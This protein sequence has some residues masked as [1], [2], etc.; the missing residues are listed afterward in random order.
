MQTFLPQGDMY[1]LSAQLDT[2]PVQYWALSF[3]DF[4]WGRPKRIEEISIDT[5]RAISLTESRDLEGGIEVGLAL[6]N[7]RWMLLLLC[8]LKVSR[9]FLDSLLLQ[10]KSR[11]TKIFTNCLCL[12]RLMY[13]ILSCEKNCILEL[14]FILQA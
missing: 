6:P 2:W 11:I 7:L 3:T 9:P 8:S 13:I 10:C 12:L 1:L 5:T 4:G 14:L